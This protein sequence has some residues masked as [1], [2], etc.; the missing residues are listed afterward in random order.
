MIHTLTAKYKLSARA[1]EFYGGGVQAFGLQRESC[2]V[3]VIKQLTY[4]TGK[5]V[6]VRVFA[7]DAKMAAVKFNAMA[8]DSDHTYV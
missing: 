6:A 7:D 3:Y 5:R 8:R 2:G 4:R 1:F